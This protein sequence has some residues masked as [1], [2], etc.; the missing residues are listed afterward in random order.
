MLPTGNFGPGRGAGPSDAQQN[1]ADAQRSSG[2]TAG[3]AIASMPSTTSAASSRSGAAGLP[4]E[5]RRAG[6]TSPAYEAARRLHASSVQ[7]GAGSGDLFHAGREVTGRPP[8]V[9]GGLAGREHPGQPHHGAAGDRER[10][11]LAPLG[12]RARP[13]WPAGRPRWS[14]TSPWPAPCAPRCRRG[15]RRGR[16]GGASRSRGSL[17]PPTPARGRPAQPEIRGRRDSSTCASGP[18]G[19]VAARTLPV[20]FPYRF[21]HLPAGTIEGATECRTAPGVRLP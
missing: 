21:V 17:P 11:R 10:D 2:T 14:R 18:A 7:A 4:R 13:G 15:L 1:A 20:T 5:S 6:S 8:V 9:A 12:A 3:A 16:R 19:R